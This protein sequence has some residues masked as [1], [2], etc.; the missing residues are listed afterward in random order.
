MDPSPDAKSWG[1]DFTSPPALEVERGRRICVELRMKMNDPPAASNGEQSLWI[2]GKPWHKGG[3]LVSHLGEGFPCG[4]WVWDSF[5][6]DPEGTPFEGFRWRRDE[7]L[8]LNFLWLLL[9]ITDAPPGR[10]SRVWFDD[11]VVAHRYIGP[12]NPSS[13]PQTTSP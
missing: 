3:Q 5:L 9:Y 6:P 4:K 12:I 1:D 2:D 7:A 13:A 10:I 11:I 8:N